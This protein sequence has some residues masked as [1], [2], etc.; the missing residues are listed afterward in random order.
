MPAL[1]RFRLARVRYGETVITAFGQ[2]RTDEKDGGVFL[3]PRQKK[4]FEDSGYII[5]DVV[6]RE[7]VTDADAATAMRAEE[8]ARREDEAARD[9]S[10][11]AAATPYATADVAR[12]DADVSVEEA[13]QRAQAEIATNSELAARISE[14]QQTIPIPKS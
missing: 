14:E 13:A 2:F 4:Q 7:P 6:D 10:E 9:E 5:E 11:R 12:R 8:D 3:T 1:S